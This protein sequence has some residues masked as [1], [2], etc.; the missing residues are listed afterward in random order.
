MYIHKT[1]PI[2]YMIMDNKEKIPSEDL[3][4]SLLTNLD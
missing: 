1:K 2:Y 4:N 3:H